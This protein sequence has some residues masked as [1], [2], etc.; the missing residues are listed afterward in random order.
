MRPAR[1]V[2]LATAALVFSMCVLGAPSVALIDDVHA[3]VVKALAGLWSS[4]GAPWGARV[5]YAVEAAAVAWAA[6]TILAG[7]QASV[8]AAAGVAAG[9]LLAASSVLAGA[10]GPAI[11][12]AGAA[13]L[14]LTAWRRVAS[15][16]EV[17]AREALG[18]AVA[19]CVAAALDPGYAALAV[20][21]LPLWWQ[22][23]GARRAQLRGRRGTRL[24]ALWAAPALLVV[25]LALG[26]RAV[27]GAAPGRLADGAAAAGW[28][29]AD[30]IGPTATAAAL[31]GVLALASGRRGVELVL[32]ERWLAA[33]LTAQVAGG[34][35]VAEVRG[36]ASL[37]ALLGAALCA[38]FAITHLGA[39]VAAPGPSANGER[40][41]GGAWSRLLAAGATCAAISVSFLVLAPA[42]LASIPAL[43]R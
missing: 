5:A 18:A 7:E 28:V 19:A 3:P 11:G 31:L 8:T 33:F 12:A 34:C 22:Q 9:L 43:W 25:A 6:T 14:A 4:L 10:G 2:P 40:A 16:S 41:A 17:P 27:A 36:H 37:A 15:A 13:L 30:S 1:L 32:S 39:L 29:L 26:A 20:P 24:A 35:V 23:V 42:L 38:G 21:A